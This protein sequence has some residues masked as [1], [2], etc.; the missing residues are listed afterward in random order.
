MLRSEGWRWIFIFGDYV[1]INIFLMANAN[2]VNTTKAIRSFISGVLNALVIYYYYRFVDYEYPI[3]LMWI[4]LMR[5]II[6]LCLTQVIRK[7]GQ[8]NALL[9]ACLAQN[10][11]YSCFIRLDLNIIFPIDGHDL[12]IFDQI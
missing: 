10:V 4:L 2:I 1:P 3:A 7:V 5:C 8:L 12:P 6:P 11:S 9:L